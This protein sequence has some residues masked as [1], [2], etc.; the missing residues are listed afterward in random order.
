[1]LFN[2]GQHWLLPIVGVGSVFAEVVLV[3]QF[4]RGG[5]HAAVDLLAAIGHLG[6]LLQHDRVVNRVRGIP[7]PG[8]GTVVLA[9][10]AGHGDGVLAETRKLAGDQKP[11]VALVSRLDLLLR[12]AA[13]AGDIAVE[14]IRV[15]CPVARD[16][17]PGLRPGGGIARMGMDNA[18]DRGEG[19]IEL[20]VRRRVAAWLSFAIDH[21]SVQIDH[22]HVLHGHFLIGDP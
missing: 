12:Q 21:V 5:L 13:E 10:A 7:A 9:Q 1:M 19:F 22:H 2:L 20:D 3:L 6:D 16:V 15:S 4:L 18:A 17:P 14:V 11:G 8:E